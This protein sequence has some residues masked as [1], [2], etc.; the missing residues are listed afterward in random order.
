ML[1]NDN[2]I[3]YNEELLKDN[4]DKII[5]KL[6]KYY[7]NIIYTLI[8]IINNNYNIYLNDK[9]EIIFEEQQLENENITYIN[10]NIISL[11][12]KEENRIEYY[13]MILTFG[14]IKYLSKMNDKNPQYKLAN[15]NK[16]YNMYET[17]QSNNI[18]L[19]ILYYSKNHDKWANLIADEKIKH[20]YIYT[21][22]PFYN[23]KK[24]NDIKIII[25]PIDTCNS[26]EYLKIYNINILL[27]DD[28]LYNDELKIPDFISK[29]KYNMIIFL[30]SNEYSGS[31][32]SLFNSNLSKESKI[33]LNESTVE[34]RRE[35]KELILIQ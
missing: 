30:K 29:I 4:N 10:S 11:N 21:D 1:I 24:L 13:K 28:G 32:N 9:N 14:S 31:Y 26:Y 18:N 6:D 16:L 2:F 5:Y 12:L 27:I 22:T 33:S 8:F 20:V 34:K 25:I 35:I 3:T 7:Y 15:T 19:C 17:Y 23:S